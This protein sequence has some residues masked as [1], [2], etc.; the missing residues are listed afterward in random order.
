MNTKK[1]K[2]PE[3]ANQLHVDVR[4]CR[5][6][7]SCPTKKNVLKGVVNGHNIDVL[8][9]SGADYGMVPKGIVPPGAYLG[10]TCL[11]F[12]MGDEPLLF[13]LAE[14]WFELRGS[15]VRRKVVVDSRDDPKP[16]CLLPID[17][18]NSSEADPL[19]NALRSGGVYVMTRSQVRAEQALENDACITPKSL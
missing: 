10:Q 17:L 5:T 1:E 14:A 13:E 11:V 18:M 9:D 16:W 15:R 6:H 4:H 3:T 12:G 19:L 8:L 2:E 7:I